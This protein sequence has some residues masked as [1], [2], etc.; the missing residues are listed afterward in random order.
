MLKKLL[1]GLLIALP[2]VA[3]A[4]WQVPQNAIPLGRGAGVTGFNSVGGS[5]GTGAKCLV[6]TVPPTFSTCATGRLTVKLQR[7][8]PLPTSYG[9]ATWGAYNPTGTLLCSGSNGT[10]G[11]NSCVVS[12]INLA[13]PYATATTASGYDFEIIGGD[14]PANGTGSNKGGAAALLSTTA[15]MQFPPIQG[16]KIR[17]GAITLQY[18]GAGNSLIFDTC[19]MCDIDFSGAQI[20]TGMGGAGDGVALRFKPTAVTPL[21]PNFGVS[22]SRAFFTTV[23]GRVRYD[24]SGHAQAN[25]DYFNMHIVESNFQGIVGGCAFLMDS[26]AVGQNMNNNHVMIDQL[27]GGGTVTTAFCHGTAAPGG[28]AVLGGS[29]FDIGIALDSA[30]ATNGFDQ[31]GTGD[32]IHLRV[33]GLSTGYALKFE[34][35]ACKNV[36][37][38]W[39]V[40]GTSTVTDASGCTGANAN[41]WY[42]NGTMYIGGATIA[43]NSADVVMANGGLYLGTQSSK[44][45]FLVLNWGGGAAGPTITSSANGGSPVLQTPNTGGTI[46][47]NV[48][49]PIVLNAGTGNLSCPTCNTVT[50]GTGVATA[51]A[52][53][54]GTA[55][56]FVVNGGA[57]GSPSSAGT[58][59]AHTLGGTISGGGNQ[60]NNVIIGTVT[61]LAAF[62]TSV[63]FSGSSVPTNG[64]YLP[65]TNTLGFAV[66]SLDVLRLRPIASAV[67]YAYI[68]GAATGGGGNRVTYGAA[69]SDTDVSI[70]F[71]AQ[72]AGTINF[73]GQGSNAGAIARLSTFGAGNANGISITSAAS[74]SGPTISSLDL[75]GTGNATIDLNIAA[76]GAAGK[77]SV[78]N[79][80]KTG[81]VAVASLPT[82]NAARKGSRYFV[83]DSNTVVFHAT[84]AAGG[85][86]NVGVT[87][88]GTNWYVS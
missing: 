7:I 2:T 73:N 9:T 10:A 83:T 17:S 37:W 48:T 82:C 53:N 72:G 68:T 59:P 54:V 56:S 67:N 8:P 4:Q 5:G 46:P 16:G 6:D 63:V 88:D 71:I 40:T 61:P 58:L 15:P 49:A 69:G 29:Y 87:C 86:N 76:V 62:H 65:T 26:P 27:H 85:A 80:I 34:S 12:A 51:L 41:I 39:A 64:I 38:I 20:L 28:G 44:Q 78:N 36:A 57:L 52:T 25:V 66:N 31:W 60:I 21:D 22:P 50:F 13:F 14:E 1:F 77:V 30:G 43:S 55:G 23:V 45:G 19:E 75:G 74:G 24:L 79:D 33:S 81:A 84:V 42:I 3:Q 70:D 32:E 47:S 18:S 35:G 11:I